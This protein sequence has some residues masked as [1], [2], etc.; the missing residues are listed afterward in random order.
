VRR[1]SSLSA[2]RRFLGAGL[3]AT[4][5]LLL[6]GS[7][8]AS[9]PAGLRALRARFPDLR[10]RFIFEYYPWYGRDPW[11][12]WDAED[13]TPPF[14]LAAPYMPRLGAYDSRSRA[15]IEQHARWIADSGAGSV[16]LSWWG[17]DSYEDR[18]AHGVMDVMR[19]HDLKVAFHMEPYVPDRGRRFMTDALYLLREYGERRHFDAF[20]LLRDPDGAV[21]PLFKGFD[22]ILPPTF[23]DCRGV[24]RPVANF[25]PDREWQQQL[26][27]LRSALRGDFERV[28]VLADSLAVDSVAAAGFDG[29]AP[30]DNGVGPERYAAAARAASARGLLFSFNVNPGF[31]LV[32]P[33]VPVVNECGQAIPHPAFLP[34]GDGLDLTTPAGRERAAELSSRRIIQSFKATVALQADPALLNAGR[35]FFLTYVNS[36]NEWHEGHAF[37]PMKDAAALTS[38]ERT[39][40]YDNPERG[41]YRLALLKRLLRGVLP[42]AERRG[43]GA[44]AHH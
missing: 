3:A 36:F 26:G 34:G 19:D 4:A 43:A 10:R 41:D 37:E 42:A 5:G 13:R 7:S 12:H 1:K 18:A 8:A 6:P 35:G 30:Y 23:R 38:E 21:G 14:D 9:S 27:G 25:T 17:P 28:L 16:N 29:I 31:H 15:T 11:R 40:G 32:R 24:E 33:R 22:M 39:W 44:L 2:R 20:L